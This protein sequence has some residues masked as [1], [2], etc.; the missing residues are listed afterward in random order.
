MPIELY[1]SED[2]NIYIMNQPDI[3]SSNTI[4]VTGENNATV[5]RFSFF[6]ELNGKSVSDFQKRLVAILPEGVLRYELDGDFSLPSE[7]TASEELTLLVEI[8]KGEEILLKSY[9]HTF[10]LIQSGDTS[11]TNLIQSAVDSTREAC[12]SE[13]EESLETVTGESHDGKTWEELNDT[14]ATLSTITEEQVQALGAWDLIKAYFADC[15]RAWHDLFRYA[16]TDAS[17]AN[18]FYTLPYIYTPRMAWASGQ[19]LI[20]TEL[21]EF[22]VDVSSAVNLGGNIN[23]NTFSPLPNLQRLTL[24][25]NENSPT[26]NRFMLNNSGLVYLK[27]NTPSEAVLQATQDY[28]FAAFNGCQKLETIDCELDFTGQTDTK[29]MFFACYQLKDLKIKPFTLST[30]LDLGDCRNLKAARADGLDKYADIIAVLNAIT[31]DKEVAKNMT[32]TFSGELLEFAVSSWP[33]D[34]FLYWSGNVWYSLDTGLYTLERPS[35][36][37]PIVPTQLPLEQAF[38][39]KGVT[40]AWKG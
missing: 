4:G 30:S 36:Y 9:P 19:C 20:S 1:I 8:L 26:L 31:N 12:R 17:G 34:S 14:V 40:I 13:L 28:Y 37:G 32:I 16:P 18:R 25:G 35:E 39:K 10:T 24:T 3:S 15:T 2:R 33:N 5:L 38:S 7:L 27:M 23:K 6:E 11:E 21:L 29:G 22:G